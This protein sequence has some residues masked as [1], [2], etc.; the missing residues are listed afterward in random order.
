MK[1]LLIHQNFPG[2]LRHL[3]EDLKTRPGIDLLAVGR[4]T[5]PGLQG[6]RLLRYKP[7][8]QPSRQA[9][10]YLFSYEDAVLHG[11]AVLR[12]LQPL[13]NRGYRPDVILAHPGWGE[14]LFIKDLFPQARLIHYCEYYYHSQG[15][16][17]DFDPEFPLSLDGA[18]RLR[19]RN[20]L[21]LLN[22]ENA[23]A[24]ICPTHWQ[25]SLH[26][27][28]YRDKLQVVHE[29]IRTELLKPDSA[30]EL[31]LPNGQ[32][33]RAG[34]KVVTYVARNLEPYRGFHVFM[35]ALPALLRAEPDCQ[36]VIVG[37]DGVSYGSAPADAANWR[38]KLLRENPVDPGRV[39]FLG[40]VP[41]D[42]YRK[43]L[44]VSAVHVYLTYPFV[45][46][47]SLLEAMASGCRIVAS[48][49]APLREV[50][51]DGV[52][53]HLTGFFDQ[54]ALIGRV[55]A[56]LREDDPA[57]RRQARRTAERYSV[58]RGLH[59]YRNL[60]GIDASGAAAGVAAQ[61]SD[62]WLRQ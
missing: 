55:R 47:W 7:H 11:Q 16:D 24:G 18:A 51:R 49:T 54:E 52:N 38:E 39:H 57:M 37:G 1:I 3:A 23:D 36:V 41:Y 17:A 53:G 26:P 56:A 22:L 2:Q 50:I 45:L 48:D 12:T 21:H 43:V 61:E 19:A 34:Q 30:A 58:G 8:R 25:H 13:A 4:D 29:G 14:T 42:V 46:S 33:V 62:A 20:A 44:Q 32:T 35:R 60:L 28:A 59:A 31:S 9:H 6:V 40:K 10:P 5:A 15:A 27:A